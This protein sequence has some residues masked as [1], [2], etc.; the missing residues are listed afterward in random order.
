[1]TCLTI[2]EYQG[3]RAKGMVEGNKEYKL[4]EII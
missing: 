3:T 2:D 4:W 1:M